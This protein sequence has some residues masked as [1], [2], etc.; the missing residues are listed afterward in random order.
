MWLQIEITVT[1]SVNTIYLQSTVSEKIKVEETTA[2]KEK[3]KEETKE[4]KEEAKEA[5]KEPKVCKIRAK[6]L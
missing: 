5:V 4:V 6:N 3:V 2:P 1:D